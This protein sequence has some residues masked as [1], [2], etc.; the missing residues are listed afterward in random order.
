[1]ANNIQSLVLPQTIFAGTN[2]VPARFTINGDA[3][4]GFIL[5][6]IREDGVFYDFKTKLFSSV[7]GNDSKL[8]AV[9][10]GVTHEG[11]ITLPT[12]SGAYTFIL[13]PD[14]STNTTMAKGVISKKIT[15]SPD[16]RVYFELLT[17]NTSNYATLPT[18]KT[19]VGSPLKKYNSQISTNWDVDN[20]A[21]DGGGFGLVLNRQPKETDWVYR[22]P[23][24]VNVA[25][26]K[27]DTVD[28]EVD[29]ST[30]VTLDTSYVT[31]GIA[32]GDYVYGVGVLASTQVAAVNVGGDVKDITLSKAAAIADGVTITFVTLSNQVVLDSVA[33]LSVGMRLGSVSQGDLQTVRGG[34]QSIDTT[35]NTVTLAE[36]QS[37]PDG[38][39][40]NFDIVGMAEIYR[41]TG[42]R[43]SFVSA[44]AS[45]EELT[46]TVRTDSSSST[47]VTLNGTYG[48]SAGSAKIA[49]LGVSDASGASE[50]ISVNSISSTA[51]SIV[52]RGAQT[53]KAGTKL[54]LVEAREGISG[55]SQKVSIL[56]YIKIMQFPKTNLTVNLLLDNFITA[57]TT[58]TG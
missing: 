53:L 29:A 10:Q 38:I 19:N 23:Q 58:A 31:T 14:P 33:G 36:S 45:A 32:V 20:A 6:V 4:A 9:L 56:G 39:T 5:Q 21:T 24:T 54:Y 52:T 37:F 47:T 42:A 26:P 17:A 50:V 7:F 16:T 51:G 57:V 15:Q 46:K 40:L 28:G 22:I 18:K 13:I 48:V 55:C 1:M 34:I 8:R 25:A 30:A 43:L 27:T 41:F 3:G 11:I 44:S 49:G 12:Y 35:T 2:P